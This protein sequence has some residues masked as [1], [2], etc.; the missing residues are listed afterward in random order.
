[1]PAG[2]LLGPSDCYPSMSANKARAIEQA[3]LAKARTTYANRIAWHWELVAAQLALSHRQRLPRGLRRIETLEVPT[4]F[5]AGKE[6]RHFPAPLFEDTR[7]CFE[8]AERRQGASG[9]ARVC[10]QWFDAT[11]HS[12]HNERPGEL[13]AILTGPP[14]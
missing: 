13:A 9:A 4:M 14:L 8:L 12:L 11:G 10:A 3:L 1:M 2:D 7:T 6:D 5:M